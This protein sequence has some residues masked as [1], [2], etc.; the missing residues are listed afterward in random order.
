MHDENHVPLVGLDDALPQASAS[1]AAPA[2]VQ[3][4]T[5]AT[6]PATGLV[7]LAPLAL[8]ACGGGGG[9]GA[10]AAAEG[11]ATAQAAMVEPASGAS[12][13]ADLPGSG[14]SAPPAGTGGRPSLRDA[15]RFLAQ[16]SLGPRSVEDIQALADSG[17]EA[18]LWKQFNA[19]AML[20]VSYLDRMRALHNKTGSY[21]PDEWSYEAIW[22]QWLAADGQLRAR[23]A[24]ALS[25]ILVISN[26]APDIRPY[27][28]SSYWDLLNR[29]AFGNY[30]RLLEEATLHPAMGYYLNML[31]SRKAD[32]K[33]GSHPNEN[34]AREVLQLFSIGLV[35]LNADG[36]PQ[37]GSDGQPLPTYDESVVKGFAAAFSGWSFGGQGNAEQRMFWKSDFHADI[38][39]VTPMLPFASYHSSGEK[40]LLDGVVIPAGGTPES[41]LRAALD[42]IFQHP[43]VGPFIGRQLVQRLVTSNPSAAYIARVSAAF[44]DNGQGVR[45]DL[46][47]VIRA[48]LLDPEARAADASTRARYGKLREPVIRFANYLR[49]L[50]ASSPSGL[51][52]IHYL[53]SADEGLGQSPLLAPSVFNF[54]SPNYRHAGPL[55]AANMVAPEFQIT[56]ET[57][58]VGSLN[59]FTRL[60]RDKGYGWPRE[61][62]LAIDYT[63]LRG[64]AASPAQ[65]IDRLDLLLCCQQMS[66]ATRSRLQ[67]LLAAIPSNQPEQRVKSALIFLAVAPDFVVQK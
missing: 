57:T 40:R 48:V 64:L 49:A 47:A 5:R 43:N 60:I 2:A 45:G 11:G 41:D 17:Y 9:G 16:A 66:T 1:A 21:T 51:N 22:Q 30:R 39:W 20:H 34:Y 67:A 58:V 23:V 12:M 56:T 37:L 32:P 50:G 27:A 36:S 31:R 8:A 62:R 61:R 13:V 3:T 24:F 6:Q 53:D 33:T 19:P 52:T 26:I 38:N 59:F 55:S 44:A 63:A 10:D 28:M 54:Y 25:Q 42:N 4:A 65:L 14:G 7:M 35:K 15:A 46:K 29:N 18:W